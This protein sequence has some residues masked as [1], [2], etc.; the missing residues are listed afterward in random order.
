MKPICAGIP[1]VDISADTKP[2]TLPI[3]IETA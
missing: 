3:T 1:D 2:A